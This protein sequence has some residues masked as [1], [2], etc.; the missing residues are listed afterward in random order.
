MPGGD[1]DNRESRVDLSGLLGDLPSIKHAQQIDVGHERAVRGDAALEQGYGLFAR[2]GDSRFKTAF[3]ERIFND[4]LNGIVIFNH[5]NNGLI[6][7]RHLPRLP[8]QTHHAEAGILFPE[9]RAKVNLRNLRPE[10]LHQE[11]THVLKMFLSGRR[12]WPILTLCGLI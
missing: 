9:K 1:V 10:V 2:S 3:C 8:S 12:R 4:A 7:Q 11:K 5:E 6:F